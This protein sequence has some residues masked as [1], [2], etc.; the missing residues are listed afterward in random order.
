MERAECLCDTFFGLKV[1]SSVTETH[2]RQSKVSESENMVT[3]ETSGE[4]QK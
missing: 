4:M 2:W 3:V 1:A